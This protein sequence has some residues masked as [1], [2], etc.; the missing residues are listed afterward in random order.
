MRASAREARARLTKS[1]RPVGE[2]VSYSLSDRYRPFSRRPCSNVSRHRSR[3]DI[4]DTQDRL[5]V[6]YTAG[7]YTAK[8][9][10]DYDYD[11]AA[12]SRL[13]VLSAVPTGSRGSR[14]T[15]GHRRFRGLFCVSGQGT[16]SISAVGL[17]LLTRRISMCTYRRARQSPRSPR[18]IRSRPYKAPKL[19]ANSREC[20][21]A[22]Q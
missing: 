21:H 6:H 17:L 13:L 7:L 1:T 18:S 14:N 10:D 20:Y 4:D 8:A 16:S 5:R 11:G 22:R 9:D 12:E 3:C 2:L 19:K 15:S